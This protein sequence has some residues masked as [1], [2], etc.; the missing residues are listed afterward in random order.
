MNEQQTQTQNES[1]APG[2]YRPRF[3]IYHPNTKGTGG[4]ARFELHPAHDN[5]DGCVMMQ[6]ARQ[7]SVGDMRGSAPVYPRFDWEGSVRVKLDFNDLTK[8]LQVFRGEIESLEDGKGLYHRSPKAAT[9]IVLR[10]VLE[11]RPGYAIETYRTASDGGAETNARIFLPPN[12]ALGLSAAIEASMSV[13]CFGIPMLV[14]HDT[15]AYK[16]ETRA[17]MSA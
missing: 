4:A 13:I 14:P 1:Q 9:R 12:E 7:S 16:A 15:S 6:L 2:R 5:T 3:A 11:P 17:M 10:H 8:M